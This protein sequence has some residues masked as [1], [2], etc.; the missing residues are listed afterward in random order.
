MTFLPVLCRCTINLSQ[1]LFE[2]TQSICPLLSCLCCL[3]NYMFLL[4]DLMF[5]MS[6]NFFA[7]SSMRPD[8]LPTSIALHYL[9][10]SL[11]MDYGP[12]HPSTDSRYTTWKMVILSLGEDNYNNC[13]HFNIIWNSHHFKA[14][15]EKFIGHHNDDV[16][17]GTCQRLWLAFLFSH[18]LC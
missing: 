2:L 11:A 9:T 13:I 1:A 7:P 6:F 3:Y 8:G 14:P 4:C 18:N 10:K 16:Q 15:A 17:K 5:L 12:S